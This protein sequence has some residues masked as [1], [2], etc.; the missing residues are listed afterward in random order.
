MKKKRYADGGIVANQNPQQPTYPFQQANT[1]AASKPEVQQT[2]NVQ[3]QVNAVQPVGQPKAMRK[4]GY[5]KV[6]DGI[7]QRG[8]TRGR[9]V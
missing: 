6:A 2:F 8:K 5:V 4:G 3:P 7:A 1:T 9:L